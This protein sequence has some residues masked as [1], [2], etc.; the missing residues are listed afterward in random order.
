ML[1]LKV[2][3]TE[4][5]EVRKKLLDAEILDNRYKIGS[6]G[7]YLLLP[8]REELPGEF[9]CYPTVECEPKERVIEVGD[10]RELMEI[11]E[12]L[13]DELPT[14][15]DIV[16]DIAIIK[17]PEILTDHKEQIGNA[18][19]DTHKKVKTVLEDRG[20]TGDFRVR[21]VEVLAGESKTTTIHKEY[22]IELEVDL[23]KSYFSP[24]LATE[25]WRVV[26]QVQEGETVLDMFAGVG[27]FSI[28]IAK[29]IKVKKVHAVDINPD[30]IELLKKNAVKNDIVNIVET[31]LGDAAKIAPKIRSNRVI[32][33][34][35]HSADK[36]IKQAL[37]SL[38]QG[39]II[40]Y[41]EILPEEKVEERAVELVNEIND[42]GKDA[43][44]LKQHCVRTYSPVDVHMAYDIRIS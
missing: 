4:G 37:D 2:P 18:I 21:D 26:N 35:P 11:P 44:I 3:K 27:P 13:K 33:N 5:E 24:R 34:L 20:V 40:H 7:E 29:H 22:G 17:I 16:G 32:M 19:I 43:Y 12:N 42:L 6:Q 36:Y 41:Y 28:L 14:S 23:A 1:C 31:H 15:Y 25:R 30:A 8:L 38:K 9:K 39:G 10:Y